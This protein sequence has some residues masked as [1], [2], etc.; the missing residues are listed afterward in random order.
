MF[1]RCGLLV[2]MILSMPVAMNALDLSDISF[3]TSFKGGLKADIARGKAEPLET[4]GKPEIVEGRNGG[5]ALKLRNGVD[6][7]GFELKGNLNPET[8]AIS[9]WLAPGANWGYDEKGKLTGG[10]SQVLFHTGDIGEMPQRMVLQTYWRSDSIGMLTYADGRLVGDWPGSVFQ[11]IFPFPGKSAD[12]DGSPQTAWTHFLFTWREGR[13][14]AYCNGKRVKRFER[15]DLALRVLGDRFFIGWKKD[16]AP[17]I[18]AGSTMLMTKGIVSFDPGCVKQATELMGIPWET[19]VSD[20]SIFRVYLN[21]SQAEKIYADGAVAY[22]E[23]AGSSGASCLPPNSV[24]F[25]ASFD[26]NMEPDISQSR[27]TDV[28]QLTSGKPTLVDG[29]SGKAIRL[30]SRK[31]AVAYPLSGHLRADKGTLSFWV[32]PENWDSRDEILQVLFGTNGTRRFQIQNNPRTRSSLDFQWFTGRYINEN[33]SGFGSCP[34]QLITHDTLVEGIERLMPKVWFHMAY[35]WGDGEMRAYRN[36]VFVGKSEFPIFEDKQTQELGKLFAIGDFPTWSRRFITGP[37]DLTGKQYGEGFNAAWLPLAKK[38]YVT[39]ID[40]F[41]IFDRKLAEAQVGKLHKLGLRAFMETEGSGSNTADLKV[42]PLPTKGRVLFEAIHGAVPEGSKS[43]VRVF[44]K[45]NP[46]KKYGVELAVKGDMSRGELATKDLK[47]GTYEVELT[48]TGKDGKTLA[49]N[50]KGQSFELAPREEWWNNKIGLDDIVPPPWT[51]MRKDGDNISCWGRTIRFDKR[52]LPEQ[53]VSAGENLLALPMTLDFKL[54]GKNLEFGGGSVKYPVIS[55]TAVE[56]TWQGGS[57][58]VSLAV[59]SRTEFDGFIWTMLSVENESGKPVT[60]LKLDIPCVSANAMFIHTP[61][62]GWRGEPPP[63]LTTGKEWKTAFGGF[64]SSV[65][66]G[67]YERGLQ[68]MSEGR[69]GW[70]NRD[71]SDEIRVRPEDGKVTLTVKMIDSPCDRKSFT[72]SF[73]LHPTPIKP[74]VARSKRLGPMGTYSVIPTL[75]RASAK[76]KMTEQEYWKQWGGLTK[77]NPKFFRYSF[78]NSVASYYADGE[79]VRERSWYKS[80]WENIPGY[81]RLD[82]LSW[83]WFQVCSDTTYADWWVWLIKNR[84][85]H[86]DYANLAGIYF[87]HGSPIHCCNPL[88]GGKCGGYR[89]ENGILQPEMKLVSMRNLLKR[90]YCAVKGIDKEHPQGATPDNPVVLHSSTSV[91]APHLAFAFHYDGETWRVPGGRFMDRLTTDFMAAE[92]SHTPWGYDERGTCFKHAYFMDGFPKDRQNEF[93]KIFKDVRANPNGQ[94]KDNPAY[95]AAIEYVLPRERECNA[96]FLLFDRT[97][98]AILEY[99]RYEGPGLAMKKAFEK[100]GFYQDDAEF[101]GFWKT[102]ELVK[103]QKDKLKASAYLRR[104]AGKALIVVTN[105]NDETAKQT[106]TL[107]TAGLGL[108]KAQ[109]KLT[110]AETGETVNASAGKDGM[111]TATLSVPGRDY[112]LLLAE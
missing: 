60:S 82:P 30:V 93:D 64:S 88:H 75:P 19:L 20:M 17:K 103:G 100:F 26:K 112:M 27:D 32:S 29:R 35:S 71:K 110:N 47:P 13:M 24:L 40:D 10:Q 53:I 44:T 51:P 90:I 34:I 37:A 58:G 94:W 12:I 85:I 106:L 105:M 70:F 95:R 86:P 76:S 43:V 21:E 33:V 54:D 79:P 8:G 4:V 61:G 39:L 80:E 97:P 63:D 56:R 59:H 57:H 102:G 3:H 22:A 52:P 109:V 28:K 7:V 89:D 78:I 49:S 96:M 18:D 45:E 23:Q 72:I 99:F 98:V 77:E 91:V 55:D 38:E 108:K 62:R 67:G 83:S 6:A 101:M 66:L 1:I 5:K 41:A 73:G 25:Y 84:W 48:V 87:D 74:G 104:A 36:G 65:W 42:N 16:P 69:G 107:D 11:N 50:E 68:W 31:S 111:L 81:E 15:P 2:A 92:W 9:L 14:E 46:E